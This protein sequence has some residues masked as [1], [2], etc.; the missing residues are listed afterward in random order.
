[1]VRLIPPYC[2][3][4]V[5]S[6]AER[7]VF[8]IL[9]G[10][11]VKHGC[12]LHSLG[13]PRHRSKPYGEIDFVVVCERGVACL[14]IKGGR[15]E[16]REGQWYFTD[17]Y[18]VERQKPEGP[19]AQVTGNMFSLRDELRRRFRA[20]S[21]GKDLTVACGVMFPDITFASRGEEIIEEIIYDRNTPDITGYINRVFD[22]WQARRGPQNREPKK[23]SPK[24]VEEIVDFL[25]GDFIFVPSLGDRLDAVDTRLLR[26]THEQ[27]MLLRALS[28]NPRLLIKGGAGTG[29][30]LLAVEYARQACENGRKVLYLTYN[31]NLAGEIVR[32]F[33]GAYGEQL[34]VINIHALFGEYVQVDPEALQMNPTEYFTEELPERFLEK[35]D[36]LTEAE[37]DTLRCDVLVMD[38]GQD[39][40]KPNYLY[41]LDEL[42][43]GGLEHGRWAVFQDERQNIYNPEYEDGMELLRSFPHTDF[44][45]FVNCRN[46]VQIGQFNA[47][48]S[49]TGAGE[50]LR[51]NGEEVREITYSDEEDFS[52][53]VLGIVK[54][55]RR[56]KVPL[57]EVVFLSPV[58]RQKSALAG[59]DSHRLEVNEMKD[60]F[61]RRPGVPVYATIQGFKGLDAR[62]VIL[63]DPD[64]IYKKEPQ[65]YLYIA[66]SRARSLLYVVKKD[67]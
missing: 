65:K 48:V 12:V 46:T 25:R 8:E 57:E 33:D 23:L 54:E 42:L 6:S 21:Y 61:E 2:G 52:G 28:M 41:A 40:L 58:R 60:G 26:L 55:L 1:M 20:D 53:K 56:E 62:V 39:I 10:L 15:V 19:F 50:F 64:K 67:G 37:R 29:K 7:K 24:N 31:R 11:D 47:K 34:K 32:R 35:I 17:R 4:D 63:L 59:I 44:E 66:C 30:T 36:S 22:Y 45:L 13:L 49:G 38:E 9:K 51:E 3:E 43:K 5:K 16:Y 18:G 14:E 27:G